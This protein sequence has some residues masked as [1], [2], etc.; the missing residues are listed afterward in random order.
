MSRR[1]TGAPICTNSLLR[2]VSVMQSVVMELHVMQLVQLMHVLQVVVIV[3]MMQAS[4]VGQLLFVQV[5]SNATQS[6]L[7]WVAGSMQAL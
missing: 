4:Q 2:L 6:G 1:R 7:L 3:L 5:R